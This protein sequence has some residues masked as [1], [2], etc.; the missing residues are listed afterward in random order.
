MFV[1]RVHGCDEEAKVGGMCVP[2]KREDIAAQRGKADHQEKEPVE[3]ERCACGGWLE[4]GSR[5]DKCKA[6]RKKA[7]YENN[8]ARMAKKKGKTGG[9]S[10][11][12]SGPDPI[13]G[14][15]GKLKSQVKGWNGLRERCVP[16]ATTEDKFKRLGKPCPPARAAGFLKPQPPAAVPVAN[17][18]PPRLKEPEPLPLPASSAGDSVVEGLI[19][20]FRIHI[21]MA[22]EIQGALT[23]IKRLTEADIEIPEIKP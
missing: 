16:C 18:T 6:C 23:A 8:K 20:A 12:P 1:C 2:H 19:K 9:E 3:K 21:A 11:A 13:C 14:R 17:Q 5:S 4:E 7:D 22:R 10:P 15:C